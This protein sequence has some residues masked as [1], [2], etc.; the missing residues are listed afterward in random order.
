VL[1][2]LAFLT[3]LTTHETS[4]LRPDKDPLLE[5]PY[6]TEEITPRPLSGLRAQFIHGRATNF[7]DML[8]HPVRRAA[9]EWFDRGLIVTDNEKDPAFTIIIVIVSDKADEWD[10]LDYHVESDN[11]FTADVQVL[12]RG[13]PI[14]NPF[15]ALDVAM[16]ICN[17]QLC[18]KLVQWWKEE[19][20]CAQ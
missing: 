2:V 14:Q 5:R 18:E 13:V 11:G 20:S 15:M 7:P 19:R 3:L 1:V 9:Q 4:T 16:Q 8:V 6:R 10:R 17:K 12:R